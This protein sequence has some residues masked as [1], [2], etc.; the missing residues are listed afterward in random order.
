MTFP[1]FT[2]RLIMQSNLVVVSSPPPHPPGVPPPRLVRPPGGPPGVPPPGL[3]PHLANFPGSTGGGPGLVNP[4]VLSAP[5]SIM[6]PPRRAPGG[7]GVGPG[8]RG[9]E[10]EKKKGATIEAK[11]QIKNMIGEATRFMPTALKIR[12]EV[13]DAKG[14]IIKPGGGC[15]YMAFIFVC[16]LEIMVPYFSAHTSITGCGILPMHPLGSTS[17]P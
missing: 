12:R 1:T 11:P 5:P 3:P 15:F 13:K 8:G 9:G 6:K 10:E 7:P 2:F 17:I 16:L 14:R 4:N